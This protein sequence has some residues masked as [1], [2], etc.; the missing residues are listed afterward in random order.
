MRDSLCS[1]KVI[2]FDADDT[3]WDNQSLYHHAEERWAEVLSPFGTFEE[4]SAKLY[5]VET[6]NMEELGYGTK[7]FFMSLIQTALMVA[8]ERLTASQTAQILDIARSLLHNPATPL[9]GVPETLAKICDSGRY[10]MVLLTKGDPLEQ[11]QKIGRSGLAQYFDYID[12]VS[13]KTVREYNF[14]FA[15]YGISPAEFLMV[16]NSFKSDIAPVLELGGYAVH[17]P[18][19]LTWEHERMEE[20]DHPKLLKINTFS[21]LQDLL[22]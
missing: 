14:L 12:I 4:L 16:G 22:L 19:H 13:G 9:P 8:G 6:A 7:A 21:Q 11:E 10:K 3:L 15:K 5:G 18:Y 17:I 20:Y 1:S 2:A